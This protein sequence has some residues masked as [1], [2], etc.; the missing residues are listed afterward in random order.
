MK[1]EKHQKINKMMMTFD[2]AWRR[3]VT[4]GILALGKGKQLQQAA[5]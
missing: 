5:V 2:V 1:F 4:S 3:V